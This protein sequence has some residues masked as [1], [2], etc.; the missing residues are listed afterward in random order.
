MAFDG[1]TLHAV[2]NELQILNSAKVNGIFQPDK[3]SLLIS[4]YNGNNFA[5]NIDTTASNYRIH[6][7]THTKKNPL[8]ALSFCMSL[9]KQLNRAKIE[10]IYMKDLE[11]ICYIKFSTYNEMNDLV[12]KTL[13][14]ELM[15]KY[16][17][18]ILVND[19]FKIIDALKKFDNFEINN[20]PIK[21]AD[22]EIPKV[23]KQ[24]KEPNFEKAR[25]IMPGR[26]YELPYDDKNNF[27]NVDENKFIEIIENS[28][29]KTL[30]SA[31]PNLFTGISKLFVQNS[32][33]TLELTNTISKKSLKYL[34]EY[35][36]QILDSKNA[37][38][39]TLIKNKNNYSIG[40]EKA[41][42]YEKL[43]SSQKLKIENTNEEINKKDLNVNN[44]KI[45]DYFK[46]INNNIE[47]VN[48]KEN[49]TEN[50]FSKKDK[51]IVT[52]DSKKISILENLK[53]NFEL[54]DFYY[55]KDENELFV[56]YR[57]SLLKILDN[58]LDK[59]TKKLYNIN[60][61]IN[62]CKSMDKYKIY[63]E[64]L[65]A[66]IYKLQNINFE[67]YYNET[68]EN[69]KEKEIIVD[70]SSYNENKT[71]DDSK[72]TKQNDNKA[73]N[74][75]QPKSNNLVTIQLE[76]YYDNN[77]LVSIK[78][79]PKLSIS[80]NAE[81]YFKKYDKMKRTL[82]VCNKQKKQTNKELN[83]LG[84]IIDEL[85]TCTTISDIDE[86]YE[87]IS[88]NILFNEVTNKSAK[89]NKKEDKSMLLNYLKFKVDDFDVLVGKNNKQN[90]Y[91]TLKVANENDYWFHTK[92]IHGSHL[93]LRCN[94]I[95][96]KN[97]T[98]KRCAEIAAY[99]SKAKFSSHVPVDYTQVKNVKKPKGA[100]PGYVIYK[101][102]KTIYVTPQI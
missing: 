1:I 58:T 54:D 81:E 11:R 30:E 80:K 8:N 13:I 40:L 42:I 90:D 46:G 88:E 3:N 94:G 86:V 47:N 62:I 71:I 43:N 17:N 91:I 5:I 4:V 9:R 97:E 87:E 76:N 60:E 33:K 101:N 77:N 32:L 2:V 56:N 31:L 66:N 16:S 25:G 102:N 26:K 37:K 35:I 65:I 85:D 19:D 70:V 82:E 14:V 73:N 28:N 6:V 36:N 52:E 53:I 39:L 23:D 15:G 83:Y 34:Y 64:L 96:P 59:L 10:K 49:Y 98:I 61:K 48:N 44:C 92:D 24:K 7:T 63:G 57:N 21:S 68:N 51:K 72:K 22:K 75:N 100:V 38:N 78:I 74:K 69:T 41:C 99:H 18:I 50:G 55:E 93:I 45:N 79:N 12:N 95:T 20:I 27:I 67:N 84:T 89:K 29:Y